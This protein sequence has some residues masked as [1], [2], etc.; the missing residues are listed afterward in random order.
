[1]KDNDL[2]PNHPGLPED[3]QDKPKRKRIINKI[4]AACLMKKKE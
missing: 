3:E 4:K 1:M 2:Q